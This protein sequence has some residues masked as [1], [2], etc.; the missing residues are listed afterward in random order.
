MVGDPGGRSEERNLLDDDDPA[1]A[2]W[3]PSRSRSAGCSA[4]AGR[5]GSWSTT[6]TG[7]AS[8]ACSTSCARSASTPPSTRW[9]PGSRCGPA[10]RAS[11][12]SASPSSPTCSCRP[13]TTAACT[14]HRGCE[15]QIGG[16][17][18]WGNILQG[19]DLIRR[20]VG[21]HRPRPVLAAAHRARRLQAGQDHR[22]PR[23]A[24]GRAH[25]AVPVLPA[26]DAHRRPPGGRVPGQVHPA[27]PS[28]R[29]PRSSPSTTPAPERRAASGAW[30]GRSPRSCT[31]PTRPPR[32]RR[33]PACCSAGPL[34]DVDAATLEAVAA[35][36][37]DRRPS[38][39]PASAPASTVGRPAGRVRRLPPP[40]ARPAGCSSRAA[41]GERRA[42]RRRSAVVTDADLLHGRYLL[43]RRGKADY[44][45][46]VA[47]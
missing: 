23:V 8:S 31:A 2:T 37:P 18:Q 42:G 9:W 27:R 7:P 14:T 19:V 32:P 46:V 24:G 40:R 45:L 20:T 29:S 39:G 6:S 41:S 26:L 11:T 17:D 43:L 22:R 28:T 15:L 1:P 13:T 16:S 34:D 21:G 38:T 44:R 10:W 5:R 30:P 35:E 4:P 3:R 12:A 33:P 25:L 47:T 36:V